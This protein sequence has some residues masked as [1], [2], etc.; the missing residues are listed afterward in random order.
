MNGWALG[1]HPGRDRV[2]SKARV[3]KQ[4]SMKSGLYFHPSP[5]S[6][7]ICRSCH[8]IKFNDIS[9]FSLLYHRRMGLALGLIP[10]CFLS[11]NFRMY[12]YEVPPHRKS[13]CEN[14]RCRDG[15]SSICFVNAVMAAY[16]RVLLTIHP[17]MKGTSDSGLPV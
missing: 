5:L 14:V 17:S 1:V 2:V 4:E 7:L 12:V 6:S 11:P 9:L 13:S 10:I 8:Q 15:S 16:A 3:D